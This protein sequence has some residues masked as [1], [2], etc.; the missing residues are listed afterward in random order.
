M[1]DTICLSFQF[2]MQPVE[3]ELPLLEQLRINLNEAKV[4]DVDGNVLKFED[5]ISVLVYHLPIEIRW[6]VLGFVTFTRAKFH[7]AVN[8]QIGY[9]RSTRRMLASPFCTVYNETTNLKPSWVK[10]IQ[11]L[12]DRLKSRRG[13]RKLPD[14][15]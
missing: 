8:N 4:A 3:E 12:K 11:R 6:K 2:S 13:K 15:D 7:S 10:V 5:H 14:M 9:L 1:S